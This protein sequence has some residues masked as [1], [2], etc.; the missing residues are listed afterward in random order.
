[1]ELFPIKGVGAGQM[2]ISNIKGSQ[3]V[4]LIQT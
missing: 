2:T 1:M 3:H 4:F